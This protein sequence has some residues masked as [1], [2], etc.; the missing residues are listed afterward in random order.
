MGS[1]IL[2]PIYLTATFETFLSAGSS[3]VAKLVQSA[4]PPFSTAT[5]RCLAFAEIKTA[6]CY[7]LQTKTVLLSKVWSA[8]CGDR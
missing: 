2:I 4:I 1:R 5:R 3:A 7:P 6:R 8:R